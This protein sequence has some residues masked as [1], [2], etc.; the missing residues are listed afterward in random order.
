MENKEIRGEKQHINQQTSMG[1]ARNS[2]WGGAVLG[3]AAGGM[4][5]WGRSPQRSKMLHFFAKIT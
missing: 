4:R 1:V 3:P 2:Q 5:V